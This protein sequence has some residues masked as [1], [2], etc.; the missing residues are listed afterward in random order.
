MDNNLQEAIA[1]IKSGKKKEGGQ[2]LAE[3]VKKDPRN[4]NAWLWLSSCVNSDP[5]RIFCLNKVLEID[6]NHNVARSAL[7]KLQQPDP[8]TEKEI[9]GASSESQQ[10]S[11]N[12]ES[13]QTKSTTP[14]VETKKSAFQSK[15]LTIIG[16]IGIMIGT[17]FPWADLVLFSNAQGQAV[18]LYVS[19]GDHTYTLAEYSGLSIAPGILT[20]II[21]LAIVFIAI[22]QHTKSG[23]A[24]SLV[25]SLLALATLLMAWTW[26]IFFAPSCMES[27]FNPNASCYRNGT[28]FGYS[29]STFSLFLTFIFGLIPNP[30]N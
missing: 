2:M 19:E 10:S 15:Y 3:I 4:I 28:G 26:T 5:Q 30:K 12:Q 9:L 1:L 20:A 6:P 22:F 25:S 17:V 23:K 18:G 16:G 27:L 24:N 29:L 14:N 7:V 11:H 8:P 21:G 13:S